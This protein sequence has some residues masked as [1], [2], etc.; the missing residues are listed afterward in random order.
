MIELLILIS[1]IV[2]MWKFSSS[3]NATAVATEQKAQVWAEGLIKDSVVERQEIHAEW[4]QQMKTLKE[5]SEDPENF[6]IVSHHDM[7][8]EMK[9]K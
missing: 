6:T 4:K 3:I 9:V 5:K 2:T 1:G 7:L 8:T